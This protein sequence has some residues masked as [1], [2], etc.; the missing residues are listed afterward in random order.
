MVGRCRARNRARRDGDV[1]VDGNFVVGEQRQIGAG[2]SATIRQGAVTAGTA[3]DVGADDDVPRV[4][5]N[6]TALAASHAISTEFAAGE[7]HGIF[8]TELDRATIAAVASRSIDQRTLV[9]HGIVIGPDVDVTAGR[10]VAVPAHRNERTAVERHI[11]ARP[12]ADIAATHATAA[13]R[14]QC[15]ADGHIAIGNDLD[16]PFPDHDIRRRSQAVSI[17]DVGKIGG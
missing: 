14:R 2:S 6:G 11:A 17:N 15:T 5:Q 12:N 8:C 16:A 9:R 10:V 7:F 13:F 4:D 3:Q 1:V